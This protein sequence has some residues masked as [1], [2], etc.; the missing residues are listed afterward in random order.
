VKLKDKVQYALDEGRMLILGMQ[1]L[2][3]FDLQAVFMRSFDELPLAVRATRVVNLSLLLV[4]MTLLLAPVAR[5]RIV[6]SGSDTPN[7]HAFSRSMT[8]CALMPF[9]LA[10]ALDFFLVGFRVS[11]ART[12]IA[13]AIPAGV[14]AIAAWYGLPWASGRNYRIPEESAMPAETTKLKDKIGHVLTEARVV[15]PGTQA[16]LGFQFA[17]VLQPGFETLP[18]SSKLVHVASLVCLGASVV[19]LML[20]AAF[21]RIAEGG[22]ISERLHRFSSVAIVLAMAALAFAVAG[23][24]FV[25]VRKATDSTTAAGVV[26]GAWLA[27]SIATWFVLMLVLRK[28]HERRAGGKGGEP[29]KTPESQRVFAY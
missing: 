18:P 2:L 28:R 21:H 10:L 24:T 5:H 26:A 29:P 8:R 17:A 7:L 13:L 16:L 9:A 23:D 27:L 25:T 12:G 11:G 15:L 22:E 14:V 3:G 19:L 6:D 4:A 20:P 1:V